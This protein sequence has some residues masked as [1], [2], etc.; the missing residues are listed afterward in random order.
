MKR[1]SIQSFTCQSHRP[2][3]A[4]GPCDSVAC[5]SPEVMS[6]SA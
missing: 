5:C 2:D 3:S 4:S 6:D 1:Q